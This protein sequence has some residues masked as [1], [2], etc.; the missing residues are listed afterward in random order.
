MQDFNDAF[1]HLL[2]LLSYELVDRMGVLVGWPSGRRS[3]HRRPIPSSLHAGAPEPAVADDIPYL[4][5]L[6]FGR[7]EP[8]H[9]ESV[10]PFVWTTVSCNC[11]AAGGHDLLRKLARVEHRAYG[12]SGTRHSVRPGRC[13]AK[14]TRCPGV[15]ECRA[16][17]SHPLGRRFGGRAIVC[18]LR[19]APCS[20]DCALRC[21]PRVPVGQNSGRTLSG[22]SNMIGLE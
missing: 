21:C 12:T 10:R 2:R 18:G 16:Q 14:G 13:G 11:S 19:G 22:T 15:V 1:V 3:T 8:A 17:P 20:G 7:G 4:Q 6:L 5:T 9:A